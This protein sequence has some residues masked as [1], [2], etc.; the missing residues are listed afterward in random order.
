MAES[1][2]GGWRDGACLRLSVQ[3]PR[4]T[5]A[6]GLGVGGRLGW[7][8]PRSSV[9]SLPLLRPCQNE[10]AAVGVPLPG[11]SDVALHPLPAAALAGVLE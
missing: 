1:R 9:L 10:R 5:L 8:W 6:T 2:D 3:P 11:L 4:G 7:W